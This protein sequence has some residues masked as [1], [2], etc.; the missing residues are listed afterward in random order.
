M[1]TRY[2]IKIGSDNHPYHRLIF[3]LA[4]TQFAAYKRAKNKCGIN[5]FVMYIIG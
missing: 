5:E 1:L 2:P 3:I 4:K